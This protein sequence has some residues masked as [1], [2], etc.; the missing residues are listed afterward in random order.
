MSLRKVASSRLDIPKDL[1]AVMSTVMDGLKAQSG[2]SDAM[3]QAADFITTVV[4]VVKV[5]QSIVSA[6]FLP[7]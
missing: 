4:R 7:P 2:W 5:S 3:L 1:T 6:Y